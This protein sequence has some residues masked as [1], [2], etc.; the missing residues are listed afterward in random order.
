MAWYWGLVVEHNT[1]F[2]FLI[3]LSNETHYD[4][5]K[6]KIF[7]IRKFLNRKNRKKSEH[8]KKIRNRLKFQKISLLFRRSGHPGAGL[9]T[10]I[11]TRGK[12]LRPITT[13]CNFSSDKIRLISIEI[14]LQLIVAISF[15]K[16]SL[17]KFGK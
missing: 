16:V 1:H 10:S 5:N 14:A 12:W 6:I 3:R 17:I 2:T 7:P 11:C 9:Y 8:Q 13:I 15:F 4:S